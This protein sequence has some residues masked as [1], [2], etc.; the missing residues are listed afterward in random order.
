MKTL[1]CACS[2]ERMDRL[3]GSN[4]RPF[5]EAKNGVLRCAACGKEHVKDK[6]RV[7]ESRAS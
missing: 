7:Q 2:H 1:Y 5:T 6:A 4:R 3:H